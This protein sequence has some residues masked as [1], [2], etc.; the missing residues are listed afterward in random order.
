M[1]NLVLTH[2]YDTRSNFMF[3]AVFIF[4]SQQNPPQLPAVDNRSPDSVTTRGTVA[5]CQSLRRALYKAI[6]CVGLKIDTVQRRNVKRLKFATVYSFGTVIHFLFKTHQ[7]NQYEVDRKC[8][9]SNE[10]HHRTTSHLKESL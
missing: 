1:T 4:N 9:S 7:I 10:N 3:A 2:S 8:S 6:N 5:H